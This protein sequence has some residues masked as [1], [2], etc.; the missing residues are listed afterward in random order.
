MGLRI[1]FILVTLFAV[2]GCQTKKNTDQASRNVIVDYFAENVSVMQ[3]KDFSTGIPAL[4]SEDKQ[5]LADRVTEDLRSAITT[6]MKYSLVG[7]K[8]ARVEV[9]MNSI[10]I[11]TSAGRVLVGS[12]SEIKGKVQIIDS[13]TN[14]IV[15][16][17]EIIAEDRAAHNGTT[18][19]G[20][21]VG[22]IASFIENKNAS[23]YE[24]RVTRARDAF[25]TELRKWLSLKSR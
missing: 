18:V 8:P 13:E 21:P 1:L 16:M 2:L 25:L 6:D 10:S 12:S 4:G 20:I 7:K 19:N 5:A 22:A 23:G 11:S 3:S 15:A 24:T 14:R 9:I 17:T